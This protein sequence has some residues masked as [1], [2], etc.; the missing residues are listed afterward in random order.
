MYLTLP[1]YIKF[2][3]APLHALEAIWREYWRVEG[4]RG[5]SVGW[6]TALQA[7]KSRVRLKLR[8]LRF[9]LTIHPA[10]LW[11][12]GRLRLSLRISPL[13]NKGDRWIRL[14]TLRPSCADC[15]KMLGA[16]TSWSP[17]GLLGLCRDSFTFAS[18]SMGSRRKTPLIL[19]LDSVVYFISQIVF[20]GETL[21]GTHW[22][23]SSVSPRA[24]VDDM[25][26]QYVFLQ[27]KSNHGFSTVQPVA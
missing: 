10:A 18:F 6:G 7:G 3:A 17:R 16:L 11:P 12:W 23:A 9:L 20:T 24:D 26:A 8:S 22:T 4:V 5:S 2:I 19:N 1:K 27:P 13:G 15:L 14:T 21:A 25:E